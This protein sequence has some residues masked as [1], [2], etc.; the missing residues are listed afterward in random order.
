MLVQA[1]KTRHC[2]GL[3]AFAV[4]YA[5]R[6]FFTSRWSD[7]AANWHFPQLAGV[8]SSGPAI[9][10]MFAALAVGSTNVTYRHV[11]VL[12]EGSTAQGVRRGAC[13]EAISCGVSPFLLQA[14]TGHAVGG[15][16]SDTPSASTAAYINESPALLVPYA[17]AIG[18]WPSLPYGRTGAG[19][20]PASLEPLIASGVSGE[21]LEQL[22]DKVFYLRPLHNSPAM[23]EPRGAM[24]PFVRVMLAQLLMHALDMEKAGECRSALG[25]LM[26]MLVELKVASRDM[27][28]YTVV[29]WSNTIRAQF[30]ID[31]L[32]LYGGS[33]VGAAG[34]DAVLHAVQALAAAGSSHNRSISNQ[35]QKL[36]SRLDAPERLA[37]SRISASPRSESSRAQTGM[38]GGASES[39]AAAAGVTVAAAAATPHGSEGD[40]TQKT[41]V[42]ARIGAAG[43]DSVRA[44]SALDALSHKDG[45]QP[46][47]F[48]QFKGLTV[49]DF[50]LRSLANTINPKDNDR[51]RGSTALSCLKMVSTPLEMRI[52]AMPDA[53]DAFKSDLASVVHRRLLCRFREA[54]VKVEGVDGIPPVLKD[55]VKKDQG[56]RVLTVCSVTDHI[57]ALTALSAVGGGKV[58]R[59]AREA[60]AKSAAA[61]SEGA[62]AGAGAGVGGASAGGSAWP[63]APTWKRHFESGSLTA[64]ERA[65][66]DA[67]LPPLIR[68]FLKT[69]AALELSRLQA[70]HAAAE[71][72]HGGP[73]PRNDA[74]F[75]FVTAAAGLGS[76]GVGGGAG[77]EGSGAPA[78][79]SSPP[80]NRKRAAIDTSDDP[81]PDESHLVDPH[82]TQQYRQFTHG[83]FRPKPKMGKK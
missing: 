42:D 62:G 39:V 5:S 21:M 68:G 74:L 78:P 4:A 75:E 33:D 34:Y 41:T 36:F 79:R 71:T 22:A 28:M 15:A 46:K 77:A 57:T 2:C 72:M 29:S 13:T 30:E 32:A 60:A 58:A 12:P 76:G 48:T 59:E 73:L 16:A 81:H 11:Q 18:G 47:I 65:A 66:A 50:L 23:H 49:P 9:S 1:G 52:M 69:S 14:A 20:T 80:S 17:R 67:K 70:A 40:T 27:A 8:K 25:H 3:T 43:D 51:S 64:A 26:S 54:Y 82:T 56:L 7:D 44:P 61:S 55:S 6:I 37:A 35:I 83:D 10:D 53:V 19:S 45:A 31:N 24:R 38:G 63:S